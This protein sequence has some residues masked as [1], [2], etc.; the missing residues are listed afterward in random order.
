MIL[1]LRPPSLPSALYL[2]CLYP[3]CLPTKAACS[4]PSLELNMLPVRVAC[5]QALTASHLPGTMCMSLCHDSHAGC[6]NTLEGPITALTC[7]V[8]SVHAIT[9]R[10]VKR[11]KRR[12][13]VLSAYQERLPSSSSLHSV[14]DLSHS[15]SSLAAGVHTHRLG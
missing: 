2:H 7:A 15:H 12:E 3:R 8:T 11:C 6:D 10:Q 9:L 14:D 4:I 5:T 13:S 1:L